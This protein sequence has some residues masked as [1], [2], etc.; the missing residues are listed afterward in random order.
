MKITDML[1]KKFKLDYCLDASNIP[2]TL[3]LKV[4]ASTA[5]PTL[6]TLHIG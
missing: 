1:S 6:K 4:D 3:K 2:D 5:Q